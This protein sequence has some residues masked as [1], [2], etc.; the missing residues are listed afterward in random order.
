VP[1]L[2]SIWMAKAW[3]LDTDTKGTGA[4]MVPL[5]KLERRRQRGRDRERIS[6][7]RRTPL[8]PE[9]PAED[10]ARDDHRSFKLVNVLTREVVG[11]GVGP[12]EAVELLE[13]VRSVVDV[14]IYVWE[15]ELEDWR[16]LSLREKKLMWEFR[17]R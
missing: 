8:P 7:I 14:R 3:V 1:G 15:P 16:A 9:E 11:D 4:E 12:R 2:D 17:G 13:A 10:S 5:E 6:V